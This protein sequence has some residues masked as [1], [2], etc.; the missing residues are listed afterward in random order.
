MKVLEKIPFLQIDGIPQLVKDFLSGQLHGLEHCRFSTAGFKKKIEEKSASYTS[1]QRRIL[2]NVLQEQHG[3]VEC[4]E[5]QKV[6]LTS[7]LSENTFTV[8]TGHQLNLFS[9]PSFFIYKILQTIKTAEFLSQEFPDKK[10]VPVFWMATEDHDFD[11]INHFKTLQ[12]FYQ[13][14]ENS[15]GAVGRIEVSD[16]NFIRHFEEEFRDSVFGT[17]LIRWIKEAYKQGVSLSH[18][19]RN[20]V[21]RLFSDYGLLIIDGD[22]RALKAQMKEI[23]EEE[24]FHS[25]L[26]ETTKGQIECLTEK[27]GRVQVNPREINLFYLSEMRN[28]IEAEGDVFKIVDQ[29]L[30]F[31]H[32]EILHELRNHPEKFSPN[33][34]MRPVYQEKVLPNIAYIGGNAEIMYWLE[35]KDYFEAV[36]LPMPLLIPR[37]SMLFLN[38]KTISKSGK[39]GL[40]LRELFGD[41]TKITDERILGDNKILMKINEMRQVIAENFNSLK[42]LAAQTEKTFANLVEAEEVRQLKSFEKMKKRL[43]RAEKIKQAELLERL[44]RLY[45]EVH[46][47]GNWQ[48]RVLNFSVFYAD[49]GRKWIEACYQAMDVQNSELIIMSV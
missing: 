34:L 29:E 48:E 15:G 33:A 26:L 18:A 1:Q 8:V 32:E 24:I 43:L 35:L 9:G 39:L 6:N 30:T 40:S 45:L 28:R 11:E 10:F 5:K 36:G 14:S 37:N 27:Y 21:Q 31:T 23:F 3:I 12:N 46:P 17:E 25:A 22:D 19:T 42:T 41:F 16:V 20:L 38:E 44:Q 13:I 47:Q 7:L 4:S 2:Y 49:F